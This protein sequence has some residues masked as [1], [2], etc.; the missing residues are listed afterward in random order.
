MCQPVNGSMNRFTDHARNYFLA[1]YGM[2][3]TET[4]VFGNRHEYDMHQV[5]LDVARQTLTDEM[6][7][8]DGDIDQ[9]IETLAK[10]MKNH[11]LNF[12][13]EE[14]YLRGAP[15]TLV[16]TDLLIVAIDNVDWHHI[17][18]QFIKEVCA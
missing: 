17:A 11:F 1:G 3:N 15:F 5:T 4:T 13:I 12:H 7:K 6:N 16:A 9:A 18:E 8:P 10:Q 14:N 2:N